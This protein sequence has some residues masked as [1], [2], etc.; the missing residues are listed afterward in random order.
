MKS[1]TNWVELTKCNIKK[2]PKDSKG[3]YV[4]RTTKNIETNKSDIIYIGSAGTGKQTVRVRLQNLLRGINCKNGIIA[5]NVHTASIE[6]R[7]HAKNKLEFSWLECFQAPDGVEKAFLLAFW[8]STGKRP[9]C[10]KRF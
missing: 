6:I 3:V 7:K 10:N 9:T 1:W 8:T 2:V 5:K 4:I